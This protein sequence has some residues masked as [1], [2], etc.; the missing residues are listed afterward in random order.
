MAQETEATIRHMPAAR[1]AGPLDWRGPAW[2]GLPG[3]VALAG[4]LAAGATVLAFALIAALGHAPLA[5]AWGGPAQ[6]YAVA[7]AG[8]V[9]AAF[10]L[11][12]ALSPAATRTSGALFAATI[13]VGHG[14]LLLGYCL[15]VFVPGLAGALAP[16]SELPASSALLVPAVLREGRPEGPFLLLFTLFTLLTPLILPL[17]RVLAL[18]EVR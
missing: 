14:L 9:A 2:L 15:V 16:L 8:L 11:A 7:L 17:L 5:E 3:G 1:I 12:I 13:A 4:A 18:R 10:V 6:R